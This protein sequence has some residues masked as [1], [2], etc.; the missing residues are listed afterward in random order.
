[1]CRGLQ[2]KRSN[3]IDDH[4]Q[5]HHHQEGLNSVSSAARNCELCGERARLYCQA[6]NAY[7]CQKCD[8]YVHAANFLA[9]RHIRCLL[10]TICHGFTQRYLVGAST[11]VVVPELK[12]EDQEVEEDEEQC[13]EEAEDASV[14]L[15]F[16]FL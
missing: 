6:D 14:K 9:Q 15:P 13:S 5:H 2:Q 7:L 16:L 4:H 12:E 3:A 1:M 8:R 10:C 11:E